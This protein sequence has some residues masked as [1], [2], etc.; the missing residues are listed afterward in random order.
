MRG[1]VWGGGIFA[2]KM[3]P[4]IP[5]ILLIGGI[6]EGKNEPKIPNALF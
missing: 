4:K 6:F 3:G 5:L 2:Q 1:V